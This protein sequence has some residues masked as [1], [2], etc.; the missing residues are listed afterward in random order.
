MSGN[1]I[2]TERDGVSIK[3]SEAEINRVVGNFK[4]ES[5]ED[6]RRKYDLGEDSRDWSIERAKADVTDHAGKQLIYPIVYRPFD[7][8]YSWYSGRSKG[9]I[10]TPASSLMRHMLQEDNL[11]LCCLRQARRAQIDGFFAVQNL[12][13]KDV[14]SPFDIGT[15]F[16]LY[17]YPNGKLPEEDLFAHDNGRRPNLSAAFI[18]DLCEKVQVA[19]VPEGMGRPAKREVGPETIFHYAYAV[20]HSP[21]YRE[22]YAE[23]LRAD[24]PRL[25]L[26]GNF[27]VF[28]ALAEIGAEL[29][30]LHARN[31]GAG[32]GPG[33]PVVGDN[34]VGAVHYQPPMGK[35]PGRVW[36][37]DRQYFEGVP[38]AVWNFPVG[39][40]RPA[41]RWL[42]DRKK[43][44]LIFED[45][46]TY[47]RIVHALEQTRKL[48]GQIDEIIGQHGGW[49]LQ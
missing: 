35:E 49:P 42:K 16:P 22:R 28:C 36:I 14:V 27:R 24:F 32:R 10:G 46:T 30:G 8:R 11:G 21:A 6:L 1:A 43:R 25:P 33:F 12:V 34:L 3:F 17:L 23:F 37:N 48:M 7:V 40:Y 45:I 5:V 15:V 19:F 2:K 44:K 41:E 13:C 31:E 39:G 26:T 4:I 47:A 38:E 9:F 18:K 29:V 20:F